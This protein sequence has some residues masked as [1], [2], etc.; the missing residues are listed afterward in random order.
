MFFHDD[1][2]PAAR[3][4]GDASTTIAAAGS[5]FLLPR[6]S[7]TSILEFDNVIVP[8]SLRNRFTGLKAVRKHDV[9]FEVFSDLAENNTRAFDL[10][11]SLLDLVFRSGS[12]SQTCHVSS[13]SSFQNRWH[14]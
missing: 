14:P 13:P 5:S 6:R 4:S 10:N 11:Y 9:L 8:L 1:L 2:S 3:G 12:D 7:M